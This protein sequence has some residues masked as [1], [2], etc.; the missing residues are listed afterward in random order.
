[1]LPEIPFID[2]RGRSPVDLLAAFPEKARALAHATTRTFGTASEL[3]ARALFP[4]M[5]RASRNWLERADNPYRD[6]IADFE[7]TLGIKGVTTLNICFEW[8]CTSG[9]FVSGDAVV[10]RRVL[11]WKFPALGRHLVVAHQR[12]PAGDFYNITW[13]GMSGMYHGLAPGRFAAAINQ[14]PM[15]L[16]GAGVVHAWAKNRIATKG[17]TGLPAAHLLRRVF[18]TA[19]DYGAAK[20]MLCETPIAVPAIFI[21]AGIDG[22]A[23]IERTENAFGLRELAEDRVCASNHFV[24]QLTGTARGWHPRSGDSPERLASALMLKNAE[25]ADG[26]SWFKPP[27]ANPTSRVVIN[28]CARGGALEVMGVEGAEPVTRTF[29]LAAH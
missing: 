13:P 24:S 4:I 27:I 20:K 19:T 2:I 23:V 11:D 16:H 14:A 18:E 28:A 25:I 29:T 26:F 21:L 5:D 17:E 7:K 1:M 15:R 3:G 12:G 9:A 10:L 6:E 22:G 8:G